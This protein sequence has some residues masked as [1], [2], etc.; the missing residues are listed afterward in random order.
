MTLYSLKNALDTGK[1][2]P[3]MLDSEIQDLK[4]QFNALTIQ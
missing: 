1:D 2:L 4:V 3:G